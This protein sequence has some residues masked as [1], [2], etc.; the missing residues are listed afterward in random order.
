M[1]GVDVRIELP[2]AV[3]A[4][5]G[6]CWRRL[7]QVGPPQGLAFKIIGAYS[8]GSKEPRAANGALSISD[9]AHLEVWIISRGAL[10]VVLCR[11]VHGA[12]VRGRGVPVPVAPHRMR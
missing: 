1:P 5:H 8:S 7:H 10:V 12:H 4:G 3:M 9:A 2:T 11:D 6:A